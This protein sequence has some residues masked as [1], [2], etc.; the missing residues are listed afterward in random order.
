MRRINR[1][2]DQFALTALKNNHLLRSRNKKNDHSQE[3]P[4]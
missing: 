3:K 2:G 1:E 4:L